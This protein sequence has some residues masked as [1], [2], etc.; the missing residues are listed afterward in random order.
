MPYNYSEGQ[1]FETNIS[2]DPSQP[3][4]T[5]QYNDFAHL[6]L[7]RLGTDGSVQKIVMGDWGGYLTT[8]Y[9]DGEFVRSSYPV[10]QGD[11]ESLITNVDKGV[12]FTWSVNYEG[13]CS[14]QVYNLVSGQTE[15]S[16]CF[17]NTFDIKLTDTSTG[18]TTSTGNNIPAPVLQAQD[19]N[20][21]GNVMDGN[22]FIPSLA[23]FNPDGTVKW[24]GPVNAQALLTTL[25]GKT[26]A[27]LDSGQI[28]SFDQSGST[29]G[30]FA[31]LPTLSWTAA[32]RSGPG[33]ST[34]SFAPI[35]H[36]RLLSQPFAG[37]SLLFQAAFWKMA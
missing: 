9:A 28:V 2:D 22:E 19:G 34:Q 13:G 33:S 35:S 15:S 29:N 21:I 11:F 5:A 20:F 24:S 12:L 4:C 26:I 8:D 30:Q 37:R 32:Y 27:Q 23:A 7:L 25:D 16:G 3:V 14:Y 1:H 6:R 10:P 36:W 31:G 18:I 17:P